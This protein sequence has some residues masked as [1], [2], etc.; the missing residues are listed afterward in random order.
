MADQPTCGQGLAEHSVLPAKLG[1]LS[2]AVAN[3]LERHMK[4]LDLTDQNSR[5]EYEAYRDLVTKHQQV[6]TRL[7]E[8]A[9]QMAGYRNLP[10]GRHDQKAMSALATLEVFKKFVQQEQELLGL[11]QSRVEQDR[12]MLSE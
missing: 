4:A 6:A 12:Q 5:Q 9:R 11:L 7:Q 8:I 2:G 10:M 1:E 3:I